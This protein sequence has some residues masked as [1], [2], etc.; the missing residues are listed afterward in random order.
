MKELTTV[1]AGINLQPVTVHQCAELS[2]AILLRGCQRQ[3]NLISAQQNDAAQKVLLLFHCSLKDIL[4]HPV[5]NY[6]IPT[7]NTQN[8]HFC[9]S[10]VRRHRSSCHMKETLFV[11]ALQ[12][13]H[14][15]SILTTTT[16][17]TWAMTS[18]NSLWIENP[19]IR[20][21]LRV[22]TQFRRMFGYT[23]FSVLSPNAS[24][25]LFIPS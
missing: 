19:V 18:E 2:S 20:S 24:N 13:C 10:S 17:P 9:K 12:A 6:G 15:T 14:Q 16:S 21:T 23:G 25:H 8:T 5:G 1:T 11:D 22:W 4:F 3:Q 7:E